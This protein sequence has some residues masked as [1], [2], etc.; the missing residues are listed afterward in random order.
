MLLYFIFFLVVVFL[1]SYV[2]N[3]DIFSPSCMVCIMFILASGFAYYAS[4][5]WNYNMSS[6]S[7]WVLSIGIFSFVI[8]SFLIELLYKRTHKIDSLGR[9]MRE[10]EING[11]TAMVFLIVFIIGFLYYYYSLGKLTGVSGLNLASTFRNLSRKNEIEM[12]ALGRLCLNFMRGGATTAVIILMNS[13]FTKTFKKNHGIILLI[14]IILYM[15]L[16]LLSGERTSIIRIIGVAVLSFGVFWK[17]KLNKA[18]S[19]KYILLGIALFAVVLYGFSAIR[20]FVGR[21][22][23]LNIIEYLAFYFGSPI[24]N[25]DYG[26]NNY[27][28][29]SINSGHTFIGINNN[30]ARLGI[31]SIKSIHRA[32]IV[33]TSL[34]VFFGNTYT[35]I[36]DYYVD[37]G[38]LGVIILM[39]IYG[40]IIS[41]MHCEA[42]YGNEKYIY[43]TIIY[44][45]FGTTLFFVAFTEQFYS[46]YIA[47]ITIIIIISIYISL[48]LLNSKRVGF[49]R[50]RIGKII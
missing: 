35:C 41:Y 48:R 29:I 15:L 20:F 10:I 39:S 5:T 26:I 42:V 36:Y 7:F 34:N 38:I 28:Y 27:S 23:Q 12:G 44:T 19:F 3:R 43:K 47:I 33:S 22:S 6:K 49:L 17:R 40:V 1:L 13:M 9:P 24:H 21:S 4:V 14:C 18:I 30:L 16:T 37:Y 11:I 46:T 2:W 50:Y 31:G 45:F 8:S 32:N 25:F